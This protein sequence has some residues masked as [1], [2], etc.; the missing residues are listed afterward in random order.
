MI[1]NRRS[2]RSPSTSI[3]FSMRMVTR[4][5]SLLVRVIY[6]VAQ[7]LILGL[8]VHL[9]SKLFAR[10]LAARRHRLLRLAS[11]EFIDRINLALPSS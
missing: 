9:V 6:V 4:V 2:S 10:I 11:L 1:F 7:I 5:R 3:P 8:A